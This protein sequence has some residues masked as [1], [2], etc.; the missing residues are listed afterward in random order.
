MCANPTQLVLTRLGRLLAE[1]SP[2]GPQDEVV[3]LLQALS[4]LQVW[5]CSGA[6][7]DVDTTSHALSVPAC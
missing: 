5:L 7:L 2:S 6:D 1:H 3:S 4:S